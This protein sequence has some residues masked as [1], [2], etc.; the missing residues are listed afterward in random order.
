MAPGSVFC[1][2]AKIRHNK[3]NSWVFSLF[4]LGYID[5]FCNIMYNF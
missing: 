1:S 2:L 4:S 5:K 3:L